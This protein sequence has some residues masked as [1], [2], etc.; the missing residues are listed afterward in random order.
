MNFGTDQG[1]HKICKYVSIWPF[2]M[3]YP[4]VITINA[5]VFDSLPKDLQDGMKK[6]GSQIAQ[7]VGTTVENLGLVYEARLHASDCQVIKPTKEEIDKAAKRMPPVFKAWLKKAGPL[8]PD[9]LRLASKHAR[10]PARGE[11]LSVINE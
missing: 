10:G 1:Y 3:S 7:E 4:M 2:T 9:I 8:A 11:V 5:K 6:A